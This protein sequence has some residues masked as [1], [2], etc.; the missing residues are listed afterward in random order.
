VSKGRSKRILTVLGTAAALLLAPA[1]HT[2]AAENEP[3]AGST[4][5]ADTAQAPH[6][7]QWALLEKSCSKCHNSVDW[8]GGVAYDTMTPEGIPEEAETWE[9]VV[10]KLRA[11]MMPPPGEPQPDQHTIDDFVAWMEGELD[12][13]AAIHPDP[14]N[15]GLHRLNRTEYQREIKRLLGLDVDV[16]TLLPKDVSSDG[17]DNVA[18]VLRISPAFLDQ[19]ITAART[20]SRQAI[21]RAS[22]K[23]SSQQYRVNPASNQFEHIEGL[24]LGT[25]GG[26]LVEHYFPADGEY[27]FNIREFF[28]GGAGY[29]TK[30]DHAH[31]V[32]LTLDDVRVFEQVAGGSDDLKAVDQVQAEAA[33]EMQRRFNNIRV[34]VKAGPHRVGVTFVQRS[35][36]QS[37]SP[38][39]PI[40]MLPEMERYPTIPGVDIS[41][42]FNVTGVGDTES[43][44]RVFICRPESASEELPCA[45]RILAKLATEAFRRP[46]TDAD[47]EAPL[48][49][50]QTG[51]DAGGFEAGIESGV[52]S[53]LA[54]TKFLFRAEAAPDGERGRLTDLELA[55]RLSFFL[56]SQGPDAE[57]IK[58]ATEGKLGD[59]A[60]LDAQVHRMLADE[61]SQS[62]V[63]NFAFQWLN[64]NKID[65]TQ[66][67]P[68]VYPDFDPDLRAGF[69]EE[70]RLFVDSILR[71]DRSA[72]DL[73]RADNTFLNERLAEHY[74]VPNVRGAQFRPVHLTD[75]N[76]FGLLGK[77]AVLMATSYGNRTSPVL[78]GA[79][80][81][82]NITGTPPT[83]PPPGV[84]QFKETEPGKK[85]LTVR[86]RLEQHRAQPSCNACHGVIDPLGFALENYDVVGGWRDKDRDAGSVIDSSGQLSN[87]M[88][89]SGPVEL[90][91]ALLARP[92]QF[93][94][95][96]TEKLMV[97]AL[98]RGLRHQD[99]PAVRA[100]VRDA[101]PQDYR[102]EAIVKGVVR[103]PAFQMRQL[104]A[105][106]A[107]VTKQA[108]L[109]RAEPA[110]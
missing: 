67:D 66:P 37:D 41:G 85:A 83:A 15:V 91:K 72:L 26:M 104:P 3:T 5:S 99:M 20:V 69:R 47:L 2:A 79:W 22:A 8:A 65:T 64:V 27:E 24:P 19:Y 109:T 82:E 13:A 42:P 101:A 84:E 30:V 75:P 52:T 44:Q 23:P 76:R 93:I 96:L 73:L 59:P 50:Y 21:G 108:A 9:K 46:A 17:F 107:A 34:K 57:L 92:D 94:Q 58:V 33:D 35:F 98:G 71:S 18:A 43:R 103:S 25:R 87:G 10:R 14:G 54:S 68:V 61:R 29:V 11:R 4:G 90:N 77:G 88:Q 80:I 12:R 86:E 16:K 53:I 70:I 51:R 60:T 102:F 81:L 38:L 28:F 32:I 106:P 6:P 100:I 95:T 1:L 7:P 62:L 78:R 56:W 89:V 48:A 110:R 74:G 63:T 40:A 36:A 55:S 39:Q 49:F 45:K 31:R 97:F 105:T